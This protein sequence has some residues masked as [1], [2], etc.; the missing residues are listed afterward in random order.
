LLKAR[1]GLRK[2]GQ[3]QKARVANLNSW[4]NNTQELT[5]SLAVRERFALFKLFL[6]KSKRI[7][8]AFLRANS[9]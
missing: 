9:L 5:N 4:S 3:K 6:P 1:E 8:H 7:N 2:I